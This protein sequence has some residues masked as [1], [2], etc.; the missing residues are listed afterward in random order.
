MKKKERKKKINKKPN[1]RPSSDRKKY[2]KM[3]RKTRIK[4]VYLCENLFHNVSFSAE[5]F[6]FLG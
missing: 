1:P 2:V 5:F 4:N 3:E 6:V